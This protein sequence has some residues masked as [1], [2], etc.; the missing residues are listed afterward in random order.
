MFG[1]NCSRQSLQ[2]TR[3]FGKNVVQKRVDLHTL[4]SDLRANFPSLVH[5]PSIFREIRGRAGALD[6]ALDCHQIIRQAL[7]S[8]AANSVAGRVGT[9]NRV[10][11]DT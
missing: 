6:L 5:K 7:R 10:L 8:R 11:G 9:P 4:T 2:K 1:S 3:G